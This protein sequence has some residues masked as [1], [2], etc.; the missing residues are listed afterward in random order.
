VERLGW[1]S[2]DSS[3]LRTAP[4]EGDCVAA[5]AAGHAPDAKSPTAWMKTTI[6]SGRSVFVSVSPTKPGDRSIP[7][8]TGG[9]RLA[10]SKDHPVNATPCP[11]APAPES[12]CLAE[13]SKEGYL[14]PVKRKRT[15][16][17]AQLDECEVWWV[18]PAEKTLAIYPRVV[19]ILNEGDRESLEDHI[20]M[21][22]PDS[23][24]LHLTKAM[25]KLQVRLNRDCRKAGHAGREYK[26]D[27]VFTVPDYLYQ[28]A[29]EFG[30]EAEL[31][32]L[33][34]GMAMETKRFWQS[35]DFELKYPAETPENRPVLT[36]S[37]P[38]VSAE[39]RQEPEIKVPAKAAETALKAPACS[40]NAPTD[41]AEECFLRAANNPEG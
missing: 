16:S 27:N 33:H 37:A 29:E 32:R 5:R 6:P 23:L 34:A 28:V 15:A 9:C 40:V 8:A 11:H 4:T 36:T 25:D 10:G 24:P 18:E 2:A 26:Y 1:S 22:W 30:R 20:G 17:A 38:V 39:S 7:Q 35:R 3:D 19:A 14:S 13:V 31:K 12:Q 41:P 21:T